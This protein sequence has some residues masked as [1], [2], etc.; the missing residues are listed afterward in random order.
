MTTWTQLTPSRLHQCGKLQAYGMTNVGR[1]RKSNEDNFL[2]DETLGLCIVGD[3][4][5]GHEAGEIASA[6]ALEALRFFIRHRLQ[7][8]AGAAPPDEDDTVPAIQ[9]G[10]PIKRPTVQDDPDAT[11]S[12]GSMPAVATVFD[13]VEYANAHLYKQNQ[14]QSME[15]GRGMGTTLTG[16]WQFLP[17]APVVVFHVGDSRLYLLRDGQLQQLTKDQTLYQQ[18]LDMGQTNHM[19]ARNLL[20]QAVG[21]S[22]YVN[23]EVFPYNMQSGDLYLLC[24]DGLHSGVPDNVIQDALRKTHADNLPQICEMLIDLANQYG[25][26]DNVTVVLARHP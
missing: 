19:P 17:G 9:P 13:A 11:L 15:E 3:G 5:G 24:S 25:G 20:L 8:G 12:D 4:M 16:W 2:I 21:P 22:D 7:T 26:K 18:A 10:L 14:S 23:P 1:V 6:E